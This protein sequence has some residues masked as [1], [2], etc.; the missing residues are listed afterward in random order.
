MIK[1]ILFALLLLIPT[2]QTTH[3]FGRYT[4]TTVMTRQQAQAVATQALVTLFGYASLNAAS[5]QKLNDYISDFTKNNF[6]NDTNYKSMTEQVVIEMVIEQSLQWV[7]NQGMN[8]AI[9][10]VVSNQN[11][12]P[13]F[14]GQ[15]QSEQQPLRAAI[16]K[17]LLAQTE[18]VR[19]RGTI[20]AGDLKLFI[21]DSLETKVTDLI[22]E[23]VN[24]DC[25]IPY[26][27][28]NGKAKLLPCGHKLHTECRSQLQTP[29]CPLCSDPLSGVKPAAPKPVYVSHQAPPA[30]TNNQSQMDQKHSYENRPTTVVHAQPVHT[31]HTPTHTQQ[32]NTPGFFDALIAAIFGSSSSNTNGYEIT[33]K[34]TQAKELATQKI[35]LLFDYSRLDSASRQKVNDH[36]GDFNTSN[37]KRD[38]NY[39]QMTESNITRLVIEQ[40]LQWVCTQATTIAIQQAVSNENFRLYFTGANQSEQQALRAAIHTAIL[41]QTERVRKQTVIYAGDLFG[42]IGYALEQK[43]IA[44]MTEIV[45]RDCGIPYCDGHGKAKL[46]P[47]GH[48]LHND[49]LSQLKPAKCPQC[50]AD[51]SA[52]QNAERAKFNL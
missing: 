21:G 5:Q 4:A 10:I 16:H 40:T 50:R 47:C 31:N 36:I 7:C 11:F 12:S 15:N 18:R 51:V 9:R 32:N 43:V 22:T 13:Y 52:Q 14:T 1:R 25:A 19:T 37:F 27:S 34:Q 28:G 17:G 33:Q 3:I 44:Q 23:I 38:T 6:T 26:C 45:N 42:F 39:T 35:R 8:L 30:Y 46:M 49:C 2:L 41:A 48:K 20:Y 29:K 24:R